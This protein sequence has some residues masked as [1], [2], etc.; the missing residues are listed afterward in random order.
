[1]A[2]STKIEWCTSTWNPVIGCRKVTA[3]CKNCYAEKMAKRFWH[4]Q[5]CAD[6]NGS[7]LIRSEVMDQPLHWKK[8]RD[9]FVCSMS[10][11]F[12]HTVPKT[13][14][15]HVFNVAR[16]CQHHKFLIL[17]KRAQSMA[18]YCLDSLS[19]VHANV[20]L[21][22][23]VENQA[24]ADRRIPELIKCDTPV[25]F[26]SVEPMLSKVNIEKY[27]APLSGVPNENRIDWVICGG[28]TGQ[29]HRK[30]DP[31]WVIN[32]QHQCKRH[33]VPFFFKQ[34]NHKGDSKIFGKEYR[35]FPR[36]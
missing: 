7:V 24:E 33:A 22:V 29:S 2:Q 8:P 19:G 3:G 21:G 4:G 1:M 35:E 10:D 14:R 32:L 34:M 15:D 6:W 23:T 31:N 18:N 36:T 26:I 11:L 9:I 27:I 28:E 17:T 25:R 20:W 30:I 13:I 5:E 16:K 12:L